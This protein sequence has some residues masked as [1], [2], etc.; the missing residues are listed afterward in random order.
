MKKVIRGFLLAAAAILLPMSGLS[1]EPHC[2]HCPLSCGDLGLGSKDCRE[3]SN[4]RGLCCLDLSSKG[5]RLALEQERVL[6]A[7]APQ[8]ESCPPGF[9]PSERRCSQDERRNGCKD[10]R[11]DSGL[12]CVK[13]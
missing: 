13:R 3:I 5:K 8:Q 12:G 10:I 1:A 7:S 9:Q 2:S 4:S 11:L 6:G